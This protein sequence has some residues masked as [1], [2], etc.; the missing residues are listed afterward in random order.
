MKLATGERVIVDEDSVL[1][2]GVD[3]HLEKILLRINNSGKYTRISKLMGCR[4]VIGKEGLA[5]TNPGDEI[6]F[7]QCKGRAGL[8][9]FI[10]NHEPEDCKDVQILLLQITPGVW[11]LKRAF[12][13]SMPFP[14][15]PWDTEEFRY[16]A[17]HS[18]R[19]WET[20]AFVWGAHE[21][22]PETE[23]TE[24]PW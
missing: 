7:A 14:T 13:G 4:E 8:S 1:S 24:C 11:H 23:S 12:I 9:R 16:D 15:E 10:K 17:E 18:H 20:H 5:N 6:V 22:L 3:Q 19:F 21:I 2:K